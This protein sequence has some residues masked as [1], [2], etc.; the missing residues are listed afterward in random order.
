MPSK[1][2]YQIFLHQTQEGISHFTL[3][4][5]WYVIIYQIVKS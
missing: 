5:S 2:F 3:P 4:Q 1:S